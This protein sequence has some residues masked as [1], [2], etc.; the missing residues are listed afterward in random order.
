MKQLV[1]PTEWISAPVDHIRPLVTAI[2]TA[3]QQGSDIRREVVASTALVANLSAAQLAGAP[4]GT[5]HVAL[6]AEALWWAAYGAE[7]IGAD[8][9]DADD[10]NDGG[11][12]E[13]VEAVGA[14]V[15]ERAP[16]TDRGL[17]AVIDAEVICALADHFIN[18]Q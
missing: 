2:R 4:A 17:A 10:R 5:T 1:H 3:T 16:A 11:L 6:P 12:F 13:A 7:D 15:A 8:A 14:L 18:G 9:V